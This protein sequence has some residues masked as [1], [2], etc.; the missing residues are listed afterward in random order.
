MLT[1]NNYNFNAIQEQQ[2]QT[3][4]LLEKL[5]L[6]FK[7]H[8]LL[9]HFFKR[10][11]W[12]CAKTKWFDDKVVVTSKLL[13]SVQKSSKIK[14]TDL[15]K[16]IEA[17]NH[18]ISLNAQLES[19]YNSPFVKAYCIGHH[20]KIKHI[21]SANTKIINNLYDVLR[22]LKKSHKKVRKETS[23]MAIS[24][25]NRSANTVNAVYARY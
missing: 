7:P 18:L 25:A 8:P 12:L 10:G 22:I 15:S 2:R 20:S 11:E 17:I 23:E 13:V 14:D 5:R 3:E 21:L 9:A 1:I 4:D 16:I 6:F 24:A 19:A